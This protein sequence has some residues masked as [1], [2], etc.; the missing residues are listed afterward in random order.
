MADERDLL[1][2]ATGRVFDW[3]ST[4]STCR[5]LETQEASQ[6]QI[7]MPAGRKGKKQD[8]IENESNY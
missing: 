4:L 5:R 1:E 7:Q 8:L 3:C 6:I 2:R